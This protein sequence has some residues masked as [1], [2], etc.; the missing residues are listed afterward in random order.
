M[1][2]SLFLILGILAIMG[3]IVFLFLWISALW[4]SK[5]DSFH[6][7]SPKTC[8]IVPCKGVTKDFSKNIKAICYQNYKDYKII[9]VIDSPKDPA[10]KILKDLLKKNLN[11]RLE[12]ADFYD[13]CSGKIAALI[14]GIETA[15]DVDVYVFADSDIRPHRDWLRYLVSYLNEKKIGAAT[16]FRWYFPHDLKS[17]LLSTWN[18]ASIS[19]LFHPMFNYTWGGSTAIK[20]QLFKELDIE[21]KWKY[22]FSDDL[23]LT[24]IVKNAGY[25]IKFIP[26]CIVESF[27]DADIHTF[28]RWGN[29]QFT[30]VKWYYPTIWI[31]SFIG[32]VGL[33]ILTI[34]GL[35][36][37]IS[38]F[39]IPG[40]LMLSTIFFEIIYG[41]LGFVIC[42]KIMWYPKERFGF[43]LKY[44]L[45]MPVAFFLISYNFLASL[46][47]NS[48][49]WKDRKYKKS[50]LTY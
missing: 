17:S 46:L 29:I 19:F 21:N 24:K 25:K 22:G 20:K 26:K 2:Y 8:V 33:K 45:L 28:L 37:I 10:Y 16:G 5:K 48:I 3:E 34:L 6:S 41:S 9:F 50:D 14:K 15:G 47:K 27:D 36:L 7:Y 31:I 38:G 39:I 18:L 4:I 30:W 35:V 13:T 12:I 23:I 49:I 40:L 44:A 43:M 11:V 1:L 32:I 42:R